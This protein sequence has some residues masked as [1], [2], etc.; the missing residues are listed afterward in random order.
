MTDYSLF[1]KYNL[2]LCPYCLKLKEDDECVYCG[3]HDKLIYG[4]YYK[5]ECG[6]INDGRLCGC[7]K[8]TDEVVI[9]P[10]VIW[11]ERDDNQP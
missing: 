9:K 7:G 5:C 11:K 1:V 4:K 2:Q 6:C 10:I 8:Y 3:S